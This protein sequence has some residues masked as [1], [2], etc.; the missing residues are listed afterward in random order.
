M[1][2]TIVTML[3]IRVPE[4]I[5]LTAGSLYSSTNISPFLPPP[6][7]G[8]TVLVSVSVFDCFRLHIGVRLF[9]LV[10][11]YLKLQ[12]AFCPEGPSTFSQ[13]A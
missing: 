13:M 7:P 10:F 11:P 5:H 8:H 4:T 1:V 2:L 12:S 6:T 9:T 3:Y